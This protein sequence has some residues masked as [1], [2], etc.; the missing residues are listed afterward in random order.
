MKVA[1]IA[2]DEVSAFILHRALLYVRIS[3]VVNSYR[4]LYLYVSCSLTHVPP[5]L[6]SV[7]DVELL[8]KDHPHRTY[9]KTITILKRCPIF[10][11]LHLAIVLSSRPA[12]PK[13]LEILGDILT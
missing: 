9:M 3:S 8:A 7:E 11:C 10:I 12:V 2:V 1:A 6:L 5:R 4:S 13:I